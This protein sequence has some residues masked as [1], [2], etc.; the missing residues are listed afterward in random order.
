M[1][2]QYFTMFSNNE[3][4]K[5]LAN[6]PGSISNSGTNS[7]AANITH[8]AITGEEV[9]SIDMSYLR[10]FSGGDVEFE[11]DILGSSIYEIEEKMALLT[12]ALQKQNMVSV[13]LFA[14]S[15]KSLC[16][17]IGSPKHFEWYNTVETFCTQV[18]MAET[19]G[20][21]KQAAQYW[22]PVKAY[23]QQYMQNCHDTGNP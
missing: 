11:K 2:Q 17:I 12:M 5:S 22:T 4:N 7:Q 6:Q 8:N 1:Q 23:L 10:E 19:E 3:V 15:L 16:S 20:I 14:H 21:C 18:S 13:G 9:P